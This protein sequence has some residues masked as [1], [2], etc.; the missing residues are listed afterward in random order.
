[1]DTNPFVARIKLPI[2]TNAKLPKHATGS[3]SSEPSATLPDVAD[4]VASIE[5]GTKLPNGTSPKLPKLRLSTAERLRRLEEAMAFLRQHLAAGPQPARVLLK[6][7]NNAGIAE[8][9][10]HRAKDLLG[11]TTERS[12]GY[13]ARGQWVWYPPASNSG[14]QSMAAHEKAAVAS[15]SL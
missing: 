15:R 8:R 9:T 3:V 13:A 11:V 2:G 1:M 7:A 10:L 4:A 14:S 5:P 12:G 6:A